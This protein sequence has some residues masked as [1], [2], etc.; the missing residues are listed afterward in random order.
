MDILRATPHLRLASCFHTSF[1]HTG[2]LTTSCVNPPHRRRRLAYLLY[3]LRP[4]PQPARL[5]LDR[6]YTCTLAHFGLGR[7][8]TAP[9]SHPWNPRHHSSPHD[10]DHTGGLATLPDSPAPHPHRHRAATGVHS[11]NSAP[12]SHAGDYHRHRTVFLQEEE[13][14][15]PLPDGRL[16]HWRGLAPG[17]TEGRRCTAICSSPAGEAPSSLRGA[18]DGGHL[19]GR[20]AHADV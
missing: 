6:R 1:V 2:G 9:C 14:K 17:A 5:L 3:Y 15:T 18:S 8:C 19:I 11:Q 20:P 7:S 10:N 12:C 13:A 16:P 4:R